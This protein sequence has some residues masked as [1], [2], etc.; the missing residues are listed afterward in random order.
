MIGALNI[1]Q[2]NITPKR[3]QFEDDEWVCLKPE[4]YDFIIDRL[5]FDDIVIK[6]I[7]IKEPDFDDLFKAVCEREFLG[8]I[9]VSK[10]YEKPDDVKKN[11]LGIDTNFI[12]EAENALVNSKE[13]YVS[14][15]E[16]VRG[17]AIEELRKA[18]R[19]KK[20]SQKKLAEIAG[21]TQ[22]QVCNLE[23]EPTSASVQ[24]LRKVAEALGVKIFI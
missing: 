16:F 11:E 21:L 24:T 19:Q 6:M 2:R 13:E 3:L 17:V 12:T 5:H 15:D 20:L 10:T 9:R 8:S 4:E 22:P 23:K 7:R 14:L 1:R 18:R